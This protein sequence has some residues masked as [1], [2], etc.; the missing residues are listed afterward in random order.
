MCASAGGDRIPDAMRY[1]LTTAIDYVNSRPHLGT[2][3]EKMTA[4][5][6]AR[7]HRAC[8]HDV[9]F[10]MGNDEHSLKVAQAAEERGLT[11]LEWCD[12]MEEAFRHAWAKLDIEPDDFIRT[13]QERH[14]IAV[15]EI[16]QRIHDRGDLYQGSY[17]GWYCVG[18]EAFKR[19]EDLVDGKCAEH[20]GREPK[21]VEEK[22]WFFK[23]TAYRDQLIAYYREH[24]DFVQ[25]EF[26]KNEL[27]ALLDRGLEDVSVSRST[28]TW[29][30]PFP[31]D[32]TAVVYVWFDALINYIA[33]VGFP[34]DP[35][36]FE[37]W[38]P[39][40]L[41]LIGKDITRFHC[42]IW[43][44]MLMSAGLPLPKQVFGHGFVN[45]PGGR[46]SKSEGRVTDPVELADRY[47][48]CAL[49]YY[50]CSEGAFGQDIEYTEERLHSRVN[51]DLANGLGNLA[52]RT[53]AMISRYRKGEVGPCPESSE[54]LAGARA[55]VAEFRTKMDAL[56][57]RGGLAEAMGIVERANVHV[58]RTEPFRL[59]KDPER[60]AD[61]QV[62]LAELANSLLIASRLLAPFMPR[63]MAQL[64]EQL[65][66]SPL[67][68]ASSV[69]SAES[70]TIAAERIVEKGAP[71]FP[72]IDEP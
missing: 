15:R 26:R 28:V 34:A 48:A 35:E 32:D 18:C 40:D 10:L 55:S 7:Y 16:C 52:S 19:D 6:I 54:L 3:Y 60:A 31:F 58:D 66:G 29:G 4:D 69:A 45:M 61:L 46:M 38:W 47:G 9:F 20:P 25:P 56:D 63:R 49:R 1:Y 12:Q 57:L 64:H 23:L 36:R 53:I 62:I 43:P 17:E 42:I 37:K 5:V 27:L 65:T 8:G 67:D 71:L 70:A 50:V 14:R 22:N 72:R 39:C 59:A 33:G 41:H 2:A 21:W 30:V 51:S 24:P 68:P 44:A 13:T 11:P